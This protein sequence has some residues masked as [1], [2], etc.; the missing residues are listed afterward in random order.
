VGLAG[1]ALSSRDLRAGKDPWHEE[2]YFNATRLDRSMALNTEDY[3]AL[4]GP[5]LERIAQVRKPE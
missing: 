1:G 4:A 5:R 2:I 3:K